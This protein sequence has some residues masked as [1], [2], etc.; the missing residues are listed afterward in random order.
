[1]V[2]C[3]NGLLPVWDVSGDTYYIVKHEYVPILSLHNASIH[4]PGCTINRL[5][6][7]AMLTLIIGGF[8]AMELYCLRVS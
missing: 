2:A 6:N 1:M 3:Y 8:E 4:R 5:Q 7:V